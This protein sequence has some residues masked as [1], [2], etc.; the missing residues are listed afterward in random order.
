M[1]DASRA[2]FL[3]VFYV[4]GNY[5]TVVLMFWNQC[6]GGGVRRKSE[7]SGAHRFGIS[8]A[9]TL[10][11]Q[12]LSDGLVVVLARLGAGE[13]KKPALAKWP[14]RGTLMVFVWG[15][16]PAHPRATRHALLTWRRKRREV[17][18]RFGSLR[19]A[20]SNPIGWCVHPGGAIPELV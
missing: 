16:R 13:V 8:Y 15:G 11:R 3:H 1:R 17:R 7:R 12:V 9:V 19:V 18:S 10:L 5:A 6:V 4:C 20:S 2:R 14:G